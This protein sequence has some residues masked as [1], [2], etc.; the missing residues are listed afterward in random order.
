VWNRTG[1]GISSGTEKKK[2]S[3]CRQR[4]LGG[5]KATRRT[6]GARSIIVKGPSEK[7]GPT[8]GASGNGNEGGRGSA[9]EPEST[10]AETRGGIE[11]RVFMRGGKKA[12]TKKKK[13]KPQRQKQQRLGQPG[14]EYVKQEKRAARGNQESLC[15]GMEKGQ[16]AGG[17]RN[18]AAVG[19]T[20]ISG[21]GWQGG[22]FER[23]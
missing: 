14:K 9:H 6:R 13:Q 5:G 4:G 20:A 16:G 15:W 2:G 7:V 12:Q 10:S 3:G 22:G 11:G 8:M 1:G 19:T 17:K 23:K 18:F 21:Q